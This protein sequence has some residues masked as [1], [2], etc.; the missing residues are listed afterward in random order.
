MKSFHKIRSVSSAGLITSVTENPHGLCNRWWLIYQ[1]KQFK[2]VSITL[3]VAKTDKLSKYE[4]KVKSQHEKFL[5][6][7]KL[8]KTS[9]SSEN[10]LIHRP[11]LKYDF[12]CYICQ[13]VF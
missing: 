1:E 8:I 3:D 9:K 7:F 5:L 12:V 11:I 13:T 2:I 6:M 4:G 10:Q